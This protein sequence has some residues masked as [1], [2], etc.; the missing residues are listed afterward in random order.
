MAPTPEMFEVIKQEISLV[1]E[2]KEPGMGF[3]PFSG[4]YARYMAQMKIDK[5]ALMIA[6]MKETLMEKFNAYYYVLTNE[7]ALRL[8]T[9]GTGSPELI[10][11]AEKY[12]FSTLYRD[13]LLSVLQ[14]IMDEIE[15]TAIKAAYRKIM[16]GDGTQAKLNDVISLATL[17]EQYL[18]LAAEIKPGGV[19]I[20]KAYLD[21]VRAHTYEMLELHALV[22]STAPD[23][24]VHVATQ[25]K[26]IT[27]CLK[28][29]TK[30]KRYAKAA[31]VVNKDY[32]DE[33]Y[34]N[35]VQRDKYRKE[36]READNTPV[37]DE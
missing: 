1:K 35:H 13:S 24:S 3:D 8:V 18:D 36:Q 9:E 31:F 5:D 16:K 12:K 20:D 25:N 28:A 2:I 10:E 6:A 23:R 29:E 19:T 14:F 27:L 26:L 15:N 7:H 33:H 32:Y 21:L 30:L 11:F 34:V 4:E 37:D 22:Q 17:V